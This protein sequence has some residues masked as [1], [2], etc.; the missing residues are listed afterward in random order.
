MKHRRRA[1]PLWR[2]EIYRHDRIR[3]AYV[4]ADFHSHATAAL[5]AGV[6]EQ[7]DRKTFETIAISFGRDDQT[8][9][10]ARVSS[11]FD[12][13][14]DVRTKSNFEI[15]SLMRRLEIDI[16]VDLKGYT[17]ENRAGIFAY[18]PCPVQAAYLGYPG[19]MGAPFM[20]YLIADRIVAPEEHKQFY[21]EHIVWLPDSYQ[22]NTVKAVTAD[23]RTRAHWGL[24]EQ[25]F[26]FCCFNNSF[27]ITPAIFTV[28]MRLLR[29][30]R[31]SVLWLLEDNAESRANLRREAEARG[32]AADRLVFAERVPLEEHLARHRHADLFLDTQP[33]GAHTTASDALWAGVPVLTIAG[34]TFSARVA[35]SL[36][37]A[38]GLPE[39]VTHDLAAYEAAALR[40]AWEP[41]SLNAIRAELANN[42]DR[43]PLFDTA[44]FTRNLEAAYLTMVG[45]SR[46]GEAPKSFAVETTTMSDPDM[47]LR[48]P[49]AAAAALQQARGLRRCGS[50]TEAL[51]ALDRALAT[52][53]DCAEALIERGATLG[54]LRRYSELAE[55]FAKALALDP[56]QPYARGNLILSTLRA[57]EWQGLPAMRADA[58]ERIAQGERTLAP[59]VDIAL[60]SSPAEQL[61]CGSIWAANEAPAAAPLWTGE[62]YRHD[63]IRIAYVSG[64][65][66]AHA[67][68]ALMAGVFEHH[69]RNRFEPIAISYGPEDGSELRTRVKSAFSRFIDVRDRS[70]SEVAALLREMEIDIAV[71]L[72]GY[73]ENNRA[74]DLLLP[75]CAG[76]G[77]LSWISGHDGCI[78][79]RLHPCR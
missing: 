20:D 37:H 79:Y 3:I 62:L 31:G 14:I 4:S 51:A 11:A 65:F 52:A 17:R 67:T 36:L 69:D 56:D 7:H 48:I 72:K 19:T 59:F 73:T 35:A 16:A 71:D 5:M 74:Q 25:G 43:L 23:S 46:R 57:C 9:M 2:G 39:L 26:V 21:R 40:L 77:E 64:D 32:I 60:S 28:W 12:Q 66:H 15:A 75:G 30:V 78:L 29:A 53:S 27:K 6:F 34:P 41:G 76:A 54:D 58:A 47:R 49:P 45:G 50:L 68:A 13:F 44:R 38:A 70:D 18:R 1:A 10:R 61:R 42:R 55:D 33:Y 24:P 63:K 8:P 22:C